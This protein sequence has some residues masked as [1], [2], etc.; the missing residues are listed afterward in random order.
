MLF[1]V[2]DAA[3]FG[4][5]QSALSVVCC[6]QFSNIFVSS[7]LSRADP[8]FVQDISKMPFQLAPRGDFHFGQRV[9][10]IM[11]V[12]LLIPST[13]PAIANFNISNIFATYQGGIAVF[14][15][16]PLAIAR[17]LADLQDKLATDL[18]PVA[19]LNPLSFRLPRS[20]VP[21]TRPVHS[22]VLDGLQLARCVLAFV[23][24]FIYLFICLLSFVLRLRV[25]NHFTAFCT[26]TTTDRCPW[27]ERSVGPANKF[28]QTSS[29]LKCQLN[30]SCPYSRF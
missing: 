21:W 1:R 16:V 30:C 27:R 5:N 8:E 12:P 6:D 20:S 13:N 3:N 29:T 4:V 7:L 17:R 15:P 2:V 19:S 26:W 18:V 9:S 28:W 11:R 24:F 14:S 22:S 10:S 23:L 25:N